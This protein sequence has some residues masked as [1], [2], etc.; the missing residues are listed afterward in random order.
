MAWQFRV[1]SFRR[2]ICKIPCWTKFQSWIVNFRA[3]VCAKARNKRKRAKTFLAPSG[4]LKNV[5]SGRQ[6]GLVQEET[7]V[8]FYTM[9][10]T[11]DREDNMEWS[12]ETQEIWPG[13][14]II[15]QYRKW[16]NRLTKQ[17]EQS[18]RQSCDWS[19]TFLVYGGQDEKKVVA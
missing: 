2:C 17:L 16:R 5:F 11:G 3:E 18:K 10:A 7:L 12:A 13:A 14:S 4:R 8:V 9:H 6:L 15:F 19:W 1:I